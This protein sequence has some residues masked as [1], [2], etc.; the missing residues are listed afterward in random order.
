MS[1]ERFRRSPGTQCYAPDMQPAERARRSSEITMIRRTARP[2]IY[3]REQD[4][5]R[6]SAKLHLGAQIV[7]LFG[8]GGIGK[9]A[10]AS[11]LARREAPDGQLLFADL[12]E[13]RDG[14]GVCS[15]VARALGVPLD[16]RRE[17]SDHLEAVLRAHGRAL[18]VL[19]GCDRAVAAVAALLRSWTSANPEVVFVVTSRELLGLTEEH[20]YEVGPLAVPAVGEHDSDA[21]AF[22]LARVEQTR[23]GELRAVDPEIIADIV[24]SLEGIPLALELAAGR[25]SVLS[26]AE[27]RA[28]LASRLGVLT[29]RLRTE[30]PRQQTMRAAIEWS[31]TLLE[32]HEQAALRHLS[33]F[34]GGFDAEAAD[35][36]ID[37]SAHRGTAPPVVDVIQSLRAKSFVRGEESSEGLRLGL[38]EIIRELSEEA[39][40]DSG[41]EAAIIARHAAYFVER[42]EAWGSTMGSPRE[43]AAH[44]RLATE[45]DNLLAVQ[46]RALEGRTLGGVN[47]AFRV[48][49]NLESVIWTCLPAH[50]SLAILDRAL[51]CESASG[52]SNALRCEVLLRRAR[53]IHLMGRPGG[54]ES[55]TEALALARQ[56]G[57]A[58]LEGEALARLGA[59][60]VSE[61]EARTGTDRLHEAVALLTKHDLRLAANAQ[62]ALGIALRTIGEV[63]EARMAHE[64]ALAI[65]ARLGDERGVG[66]DLACLAALHFQ[67]GQLDQ[68]RVLLEDSIARSARFDDRYACAYAVGV[69]G[70]VLAELGQLDAA[71]ARLEEA[72]GELEKLG[73]RRLHAMFVGYSAVVRQLTGALPAADERYARSLAALREQGDRLNEGLIAGAAATLAWTRDEPARAE[74]LYG[75]ARD[76][77]TELSS[78]SNARLGT[79]LALH[80]G[81]RDLCL[82]RASLAG[83]DERGAKLHLEAARGRLRDAGSLVDDHDDLRL[84]YR[85]LQNAL[86]G[87]L[88]SRPGA[89]DVEL[90]PEALWFRV[91]SRPRVD[92]RRRRALRLV[93]RAL[94]DE[95][96]RAP[97]VPVPMARLLEIGWPGEKMLLQAGLSRLYVTVRSLRELGLRTA[98]LRQDDGYLLDPGVRLTRSERP[99][100]L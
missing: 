6:L 22:F 7:T 30:H 8:P 58:R 82:H 49:V 88:P 11:E 78:S 70:W 86:E 34:R 43:S 53:T 87:E 66:I 36:V 56:E 85:L 33:V 55:A 100:S 3:G 76:L 39:L 68:A 14:E 95:R 10:L 61:G 37:L 17:P 77:L 69:L 26:P 41:E 44:A 57:N 73:E 45:L 40:R 38:Y 50:A 2:R 72:L 31:W 79:A 91:G 51:G 1:S 92:L 93:L 65:R 63:E 89:G 16:P 59:L 97:G 71:A 35:A 48:L 52:V 5:T 20:A 75:V 27:L 84:A 81:H 60:D 74:S 19:D 94:V 21:V 12:A 90:D 67:Q 24:R 62:R 23:Q 64:E 98:L 47:D 80:L 15:A 46:A 32:P 29:S 25:M 13:V 54:R 28:R 99:P 9:T 96:A 4:L 83:G 42:A 18:I